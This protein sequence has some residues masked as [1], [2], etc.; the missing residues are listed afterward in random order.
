[1][2]E[3]P[4][5]TVEILR[6]EVGSLVEGILGAVREQSPVYGAVLDSAEGIAL[7]LGV[8]QAIRAFLDAVERGEWVGEPRWETDELW[9]R[10]GEN[11]F[12]SGRDLDDLRGA[13]RVGTRAAWRGAADLATRAAVSAPIAIALAEMIFV[14]GDQLAADVVEGYLRAQSDEAGERERRRRRLAALLLDPDPNSDPDAVSR[15]AEF[16]G[17]PLPRRLAV[18]ALTSEDVGGLARRLGVDVLSGADTDGAWIVLSD[19]DAPGRAG[20]LDAALAGEGAAIGPTVAPGDARQSLR[21]ARLTLG[22]SRPEGRDATAPPLRAE[23]H[24][25]S[26]VLLCDPALSRRLAADR[27]RPLAG[28]ATGERNRLLDTL[29][30]WLDHQRHTPAI[31]AELHVHPQTVRYRI[32]RLR[33]LLGEALDSPEGRH[34][35]GLALRADALIGSEEPRC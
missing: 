16:A 29:R 26:L 5:Q 19:P 27:L 17:W 23:D 34:Q 2:P 25:A 28:L 21:W 15:A 30:A 1:V 35:L 20:R 13:F 22:L 4:P 32:A 12:Q 18:I 3:L 8:D 7:R 33:E 11:E 6:A 31:A 14:Y 9:R 10:L 24:L